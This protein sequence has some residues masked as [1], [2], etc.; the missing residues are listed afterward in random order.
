M[1]SFLY[2]S[3]PENVGTNYT[4]TVTPRLGRLS[5][6][7]G[8]CP[9]RSIQLF[10]ATAPACDSDD[11]MTRNLDNKRIQCQWSTAFHNG[12]G[13]MGYEVYIHRDNNNLFRDLDRS[14]MVN[15]YCEE[16][17]F[18]T[19]FIQGNSC[20]ITEDLL[21][22]QTWGLQD[23]DEVYC[24]AI[25][26]NELGRTDCGAANGAIMSI[27]IFPPP[28]PSISLVERT[29]ESLRV[30]CRTNGDGGAD[31]DT[32][33]FEYRLENDRFDDWS[34]KT[35]RRGRDVFDF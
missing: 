17:R 4:F 9:G 29:C 10:P 24:T 6:E 30:H 28:Q 21:R 8:A 26:V 27:T 16:N 13:V 1:R 2:N 7:C 18:N 19:E 14:L 31:I 12:F 23:R 5:Q 22:G 15:E 11:A 35:I 3:G 25:A 34:A 33:T 20:T 32:L